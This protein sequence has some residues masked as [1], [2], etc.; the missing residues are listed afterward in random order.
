M[1]TFNIPE[2]DELTDS[3]ISS[4]DYKLASSRTPSPPNTGKYDWLETPA[5]KLRAQ[6][7]L[8]AAEEELLKFS[9]SPIVDLEKRFYKSLSQLH[10]SLD[11]YSTKPC[12]NNNSNWKSAWEKRNSQQEEID[13]FLLKEHENTIMIIKELEV[14]LSLLIV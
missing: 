13:L 11:N 8:L 6:N 14:S 9:N 3:D 4:Q 2:H 7:R 5:F 10:E 12:Q 1:L